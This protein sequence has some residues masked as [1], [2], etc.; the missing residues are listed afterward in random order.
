MRDQWTQL[1]S[2]F[3]EGMNQGLKQAADAVTNNIPALMASFK[4]VGAFLGE[5]IAEGVGGET[6]KLKQIG[7]LIGSIIKAGI[8]SVLRPIGEQ[9]VTGITGNIAGLA[10]I[11]PLGNAAAIARMKLG[12]PEGVGDAFTRAWDTNGIDAQIKAMRPTPSSG[13][14]TAWNANPTSEK[15]LKIIA[16]NTKEGAKF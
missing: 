1:T 8:E 15:Y 7:V 16:E 6:E 9:L 5:A 2:T 4:T 13:G 14:S 3:G 12:T 11:S 10:G